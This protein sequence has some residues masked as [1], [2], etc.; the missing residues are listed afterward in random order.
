MLEASRGP[1]DLPGVSLGSLWTVAD[2]QRAAF[3]AAPARAASLPPC[4]QEPRHA[5]SFPKFLHGHIVGTG[6]PAAARTSRVPVTHRGKRAPVRA[7]ESHPASPPDRP[8]A[9]GRLGGMRPGSVP[10]PRA[11]SP[12][13]PPQRGA[14][15][16]ATPPSLPPAARPTSLRRPPLTLPPPGAHARRRPLGPPLAERSRRSPSGAEPPPASLPSRPVPVPA[17]AAGGSLEPVRA[18]HRV[19]AA[20]RGAPAAI[21]GAGVG[22]GDRH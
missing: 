4:R 3:S 22:L 12:A 16:R 15:R 20:G 8:E 17:P 6:S 18:W 2:T 5:A 10:P 7:Q 11:Q 13:A 9:A 19:S 14:P 1:T 21:L